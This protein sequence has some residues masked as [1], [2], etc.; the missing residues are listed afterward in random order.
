VA[1][2]HMSARGRFLTCCVCGVVLIV[3]ALLCLNLILFLAMESA[4]TY[5]DVAAIRLRY[6]VAL[7]LFVSF[8]VGAILCFIF[9]FRIKKRM[10]K[11]PTA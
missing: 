2:Y 3:A 11:V 5:A 4:R 7:A 1:E 6:H 9:A 10:P 8:V